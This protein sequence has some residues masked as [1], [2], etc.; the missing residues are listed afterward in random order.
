[1]HV[2]PSKSEN[3]RKQTT[4]TLILFR[5]QKDR[6]D[7]LVVKRRFEGGRPG[8]ASRLRRGSFSRTS[9]TSDL[10]VILQC[11]PARCLTSQCPSWDRSAR[12]HYDVIGGDRKF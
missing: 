8:F 6:F 5:M 1:M 4:P 2:S 7:G 9:H 12:C 10:K 11:Y 3:A